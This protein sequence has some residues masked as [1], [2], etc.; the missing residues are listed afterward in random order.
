[1]RHTIFTW[2][3]A[4]RTLSWSVQGTFADAHTFVQLSATLFS[5]G[6]PVGGKTSPTVN[7][8]PTGSVQF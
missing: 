8:G 5:A 1:M 4:A 6:G 3:D 7:I 2:N